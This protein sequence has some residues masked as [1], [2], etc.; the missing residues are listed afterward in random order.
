VTR[1]GASTN[2]LT[3][4]SFLATAVG[5]AAAGLAGCGGSKA[6]VV[7]AALDCVGAKAGGAD[8][9]LWRIAARRGIVYGSST[10]TWQVSDADYAKLFDREASILFT[11][12]DL[13]WYRLRPSPTSGLR[14]EHGDRIVDFAERHGQLVLGAHLV[15]DEGFGDGWSEEDFFLEEKEARSLLFGTLDAVVRRYRGRVTAWIVANEV[16]D[17]EGQRTDVSWY[18]T[19][20][21]SYVEEA[22]RR[23]HAADP[24]ATLL[25][26]EFGFETDDEY[27][28]AADRRA[29]MLSFLDEL[30]DA[31]VPV[32]AL[33]VQAHLHADRFAQRF[34]GNAYRKFL[35]D[36]ADR[37]LKI[38]ITE[39]DVLDDGLPANVAVRDRGVADTYRRYL[40]VA[41]DEPA[42]AS[43]VTFGL[44]DR[45]TWLQEDYPRNDKAPRRPLPFDEKL[46][47]KPTYDVLH[48]SL[49][50]APRRD[51]LWGAP[52]C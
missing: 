32:H 33:G 38:V 25:I 45:Y 22:F 34:D 9:P 40:D 4:R 18:Q 27:N 20:G 6:K 11:E 14:F 7:Q 35:A 46:R 13:L 5:A 30:L 23:A 8:A 36:L 3:R 29:A 52:R 39:L 48:R 17:G 42:L 24:A 28:V 50:N 26:N 43:L 37:G 41:L 51:L 1:T 21:P 16:I 47:P 2:V 12:D 10:A 49:A 15:W 31:K 19:I 44:S